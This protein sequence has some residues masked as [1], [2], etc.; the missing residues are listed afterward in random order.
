MSVC[1]ECGIEFDEVPWADPDDLICDLCIED[2]LA[3]WSP[4]EGEFPEQP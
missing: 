2:E 4:D 1:V 3:Q